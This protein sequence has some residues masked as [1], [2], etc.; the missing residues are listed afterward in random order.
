MGTNGHSDYQ[1]F[2][3]TRWSLVLRAG[4]KST[5]AGFQALEQLVTRYHLALKAHLVYVK[6]LDPDR[7]EDLIQGFLADKFLESDLL[8]TAQRDKGR[9]RTYLLTALERYRVSVYRKETTHKRSPG[10]GMIVD[11]EEIRD[12]VA[13]PHTRSS[14]YDIAWARELIHQALQKVRAELESSSRPS[15]W[16]IFEARVVAP[17][18]EGTPA[19]DYN[20]LVSRLGFAT[21][22]QASNALITAKRM[23]V[24]KLRETV[25]DYV[26]GEKEIDEE[27]G[28]LQAILA[29]A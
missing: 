13:A 28:E 12:V 26:D 10:A 3:V 15:H 29:G 9:F 24:R 21:P 18:L 5:A 27:L 16:A 19:A 11:L 14:P 7:A 4:A 6:K 22:V 1:A 17:I 20:A 2:P 23:F 8:T 25:A